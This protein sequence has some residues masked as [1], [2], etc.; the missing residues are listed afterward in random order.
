MRDMLLPH[1]SANSA[2]IDSALFRCE[3]TVRAL[4]G[5]HLGNFLCSSRRSRLAVV[6]R[7]V[8]GRLGRFDW[9]HSVG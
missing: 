2:P 7:G 6:F 8:F 4:F 1:S 9:V 3:G 5:R